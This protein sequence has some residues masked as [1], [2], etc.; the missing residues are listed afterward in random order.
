MNQV[1]RPYGFTFN[2]KEISRWIH[3][4]WAVNQNEDEMKANLRKGAY[5]DLN[6][7]VIEQSG[8]G[9]AGW[10]TL[11]GP[12]QQQ[13]FTHDGCT[14]TLDILA[15][16]DKSGKIGIHEVGHWMGL[17]HTFEGGC[18]GDN[19]KVFDTPAENFDGNFECTPGRDS[20]PNQEG[21]DPVH[22]YMDYVHE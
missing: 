19:D 7:Y 4:G 11:P 14:L 6:L 3:P 1:F 21:L 13:G 2:L 9:F 22:N 8:N 5:R 17:M 12:F 20:C 10:C 15:G 16:A 18:D